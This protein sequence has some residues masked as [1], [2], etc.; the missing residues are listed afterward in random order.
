MHNNYNICR[1][2]IAMESE[3]CIVRDSVNNEWV[4]SKQRPIKIQVL[5]ANNWFLHRESHHFPALIICFG[6]IFM[7]SFTCLESFTH[8]TFHSFN[9]KFIGGQK[10]QF[11]HGICFNRNFKSCDRHYYLLQA[12]DRFEQILKSIHEM[13]TTYTLHISHLI[14]DEGWMCIES[15]LCSTLNQICR[16]WALSVY[17]WI[18][19]DDCFICN[20]CVSG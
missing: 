13:H 11:V 7:R 10:L 18:Y 19:K 4:L 5:V 20:V 2:K 1:I 3:K 12:M 8:I 14:Q 15:I 16:A 6:P 17:F 9:I